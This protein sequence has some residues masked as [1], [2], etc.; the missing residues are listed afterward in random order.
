MKST[1]RHLTVADT[2]SKGHITGNPGPDDRIVA[3]IPLADQTVE[4]ARR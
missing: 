4:G 2:P 3:T 1:T